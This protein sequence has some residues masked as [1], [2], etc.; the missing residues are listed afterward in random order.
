[1]DNNGKINAADARLV[2]RYY[3][4]LENLG[5]IQL[6]AADVDGNGKVNAA[7][8]R[9]ILIFFAKLEPMD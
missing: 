6:M 1:M 3:A 5:A 4:K 9:K 7:D 8:A 2:L